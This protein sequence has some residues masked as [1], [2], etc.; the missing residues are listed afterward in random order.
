MTGIR[1]TTEAAAATASQ[2]RLGAAQKERAH[3]DGDEHERRAEVGLDHDQRERRRDQQACADQRREIAQAIP[4]R[5]EERRQD[6]RS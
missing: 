6:A 2:R 5:R 4:A 3:E 1:A